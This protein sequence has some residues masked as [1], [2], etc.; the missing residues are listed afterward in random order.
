MKW[1]KNMHFIQLLIKS[2]I[3]LVSIYIT[4]LLGYIFVGKD[5]RQDATS[6]ISSTFGR[7]AN[8]IYCTNSSTL[9]CQLEDQDSLSSEL[10]NS[11]VASP[12]LKYVQSNGTVPATTNPSSESLVIHMT[13]DSTN[14]SAPNE[15]DLLAASDDDLQPAAETLSSYDNIYFEDE[16]DPEAAFA[17]HELSSSAKQT[18]IQNTKMI[19]KLTTSLDRDYLIENF[20]KVNPSSVIDK[21]VWNVKTMLSTD[22]TIKKDSSKPQ[23]LIFHTHAHETFADSK[24]GVKSDSIVGVG[25]ELAS[26]LKKKYGY[27]VM[28][29]SKQYNYN[30]A[31]NEALEDL[32][33]ITKEN[34]SIQMIIDLH[35]DG[36]SETCKTHTVCTVDGKEMAPIMFFN[37][38]CNNKQSSLNY[39]TNPNL[40]DNLALSLQMKL[41]AMKTFPEFTKKNFIKSFRYNMHM[42]KRYTLIEVG[43]NNNTVEEVK[44]AMTPL[45]E[46]IAHVL[47]T[48]NEYAN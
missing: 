1:R 43:D 31:Y 48:P 42:A 2:G 5:V 27:N 33:R 9:S 10:F 44:S 13:N 18:L 39:H 41:Y 15:G 17:S 14:I 32:K 20:Y 6:I 38:V 4:I 26:V 25:E 21:K 24:S 11:A 23:I 45:A 8:A 16:Y 40:T 35:R 19:S 47:S 30:T 3:I 37:G 22:L 34:P 12:V 46:I 29:Y 7:I 28:H 36:V